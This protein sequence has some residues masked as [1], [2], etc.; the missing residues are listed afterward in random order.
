S[1][2]PFVDRHAVIFLFGIFA[3]LPLSLLKDLSKLSYTSGASVMADVLLTL[4]VLFAGTSEA[5]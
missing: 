3:A 2:G 4:I 5:R 1:K